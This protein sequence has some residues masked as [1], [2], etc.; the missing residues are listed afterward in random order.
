MVL[1]AL[2]LINACIFEN[3]KKPNPQGSSPE[4]LQLSG[5]LVNSEALALAGVPVSIRS[6]RSDST[7]ISLLSKVSEAEIYSDTTYSIDNGNFVFSSVPGGNFS[8]M[9]FYIPPD[10]SETLGVLVPFVK[11][12][13]DTNIGNISMLPVGHVTIEVSLNGTPTANLLC[14]IE[15]F[16]LTQ[17]TDVNGLCHFLLPKGNYVATVGDPSQGAL[18]SFSINV[19]SGEHKWLGPIMLATDTSLIPPKPQNLFASIDNYNGIVKLSWQPDSTASSSYQVF[20]KINPEG[21]Y[22][23]IH[24]GISIPQTKLEDTLALD[25]NDTAFFFY[26]VRGFRDGFISDFSDSVF[27]KATPPNKPSKPNPEKGQIV[28]NLSPFLSWQGIRIRGEEKVIY[29]VYVDT[30][31]YPDVPVVQGQSVPLVSLSNLKENTVYFWRVVA[32]VDG[33][34]V[35]GPVWYFSTPPSPAGNNI[36]SIPENAVPSDSSMDIEISDVI[37]SWSSSDEDGEDALK[38]DLYFSTNPDALNKIATGLKKNSFNLGALIASTSY[39]WQVTASDG[40]ATAIGP[41]W[42]FTTKSPTANNNPPL[43]P[44][45]PSPVDSAS[46]LDLNLTLSWKSADPDTSDELLFD[47]LFGTQTPPTQRIATGLSASRYS[48]SNLSNGTAYYWQIIATDGELTTPGKI[49]TFNTKDSVFDNSAPIIPNSPSPSDSSINQELNLLLTWVGGD[50]DIEDTINYN[51]YL[52]VNSPPTLLIGKDLQNSNFQVTGL[53]SN[54]KYYWYV[55][56]SDGKSTSKSPT[57]SFQTKLPSPNNNP[58][59]VP[60]IVSPANDSTGLDTALTLFWE[61]SDPDVDDQLVYTL[62]FGATNPPVDVITSN[63]QESRFSLSN[64]KFGTRYYWRIIS[65][66]GNES[67]EGPIWAFETVADSTPN[68]APNV[69]SS[70]T[71]ANGSVDMETNINLSWLGGD[72]D[73]ADVVQYRVYLGLDNPPTTL[74]GTVGGVSQFFAPN[75]NN[76]TNYYWRIVAEDLE[77]STQGP[78]WTFS[79][80]DVEGTG[81]ILSETW[82]NVPGLSLWDLYKNSNYPILASS[83]SMLTSFTIG[84]QLGDYYG[85]RLRGYIHPPTTGDYSFWISG[86]DY[87]ELYLSSDEDPANKVLIAYSSGYTDPLQWDKYPSQQSDLQYLQAGRKYYIE[88]LVKENEQGDH[89][90]VGWQGPGI[91]A[92]AERP[93]PGN[94]LSPY[95]GNGAPAPVITVQPVSVSILEGESAVFSV[96]AQSN[97]PVFYEWRKNGIP[98][99]NSNTASYT[100]PITSDSDDG[101]TFRVMVFNS[102]GNELSEPANLNITQTIFPP[103]ITSHPA[104]ATRTEGQSVTFSVAA[105]GTAPFSY[106]WYRNG[107]PIQNAHNASYTFITSLAD[108]GASYNVEVSNVKGS[109]FSNQAI[110]TVNRLIVAPTVT[111]HPANASVIEGNSANF[112][113]Q[114]SGT[115]PFNFQWRRNAVNITGATAANYNPTNIPLTWSGSVIDVVVSNSAG[116]DTSNTATLTVSPRPDP[117]VIT[118]EP[119]NASVIEGESAVFSITVSGTAPFNYVWLKNNN[120]IQGANQ[121]SYTTPNTNLIDN[122]SNYRVRVSNSSGAD[123]SIA[124]ILTVTERIYPVFINTQPSD[125]SVYPGQTARF[126]VAAGGTQPITFQWYRNDVAIDNATSSS[127]TTGVLSLA[128]DGAEYY[129]VATNST[130]S[131]E[132][133]HAVLTVAD[134]PINITTQPQNQSVVVGNIANFSVTASGT[135][136]SYQWRKNGSNIVGATASS[137]STPN[138]VAADDGSV[139]DVLISNG[140]GSLTS[141]E[142]TLSIIF[143]PVIISH[144]VSREA[145]QGESVSFTVQLE[146]ATGASYQWRL[147]NNNIAGAT[148]ASYVI[149]AVGSQHAG[150]YSVV[151]TNAA[152][153]SISNTA[154]L[155]VLI[156][157]GITTQPLGQN[158]VLGQAAQ[159]SVV[160]SGSPTLTYQWRRNGSPIANATS[161]SYSI[162]SVAQADSGNYSV[163][164]TNA[165]G[166]ITS[167]TARLNVIIAPQI[168]TDPQNTTAVQGETASFSVVASGSSPSYQWRQNGVNLSGQTSATLSLNNV[169]QTMN[170]NSYD[171][172]ASNA[173]GADTSASAILTVTTLTVAPVI[174]QNPVNQT[175][176]QGEPVSFSVTSTGTAPL[177][178][179]WALAGVTVGTTTTGSY[180]IA[181]A[182]PANAGSYTVTV[183]NSAGSDVSNPFSLT[184]ITPPTISAQPQPLSVAF[185]SSA[186]FSVTASGNGTLSYQW[187]KDGV[188]IDGAVSANYSIASVNNASAGEYDVVVSNSAGQVISSPALLSVSPVI[189]TQ[190]SGGSAVLGASFSFTVSAQGPGLS[191]QWVK[192]TDSVGSN[193]PTYTINPVVNSSGGSYRV[194][195]SNSAGSVT[196]NQANLTVIVPPSITSQP[197]SHGVLNGDSAMFAVVASGSNLQY[198]WR[199]EGVNIT[200]ATSSILTLNSSN[201]ASE[202]D[203]DVIVSNTAGRDTSEPAQLTVNIPA[204]ITGHPGNSSVLEGASASFSATASGSGTLSYRWHRNGVALNNGGSYTGVLSASLSINPV[205]TTHAGNFTLVVSNAYGSDTSDAATLT[206]TPAPTP[207]SIATQPVSQTVLNGNPFQFLVVASGSNLSYQWYFEGTAINNANASS[208][209]SV[210]T[211]ALDGDY[212]VVVSNSAGSVTS[213]TVSLTVNPPPVITNSPADQTVSAGSEV[214]FSVSATGTGTLSYYWK[215]DGNNFT[216]SS[217]SPDLTLTNVSNANEGS[218]TVVVTDSYGSVESS[219][220]YLT[221]NT[222]PLITTQPVSQN[223]SRGS[224]ATLSVVASGDPALTYQWYKDGTPITSG[225]G[226]YSGWNSSSLRINNLNPSLEGVYFVEVSNSFGTVTSSAVSVTMVA[227]LISQNP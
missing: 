213:N 108:N 83:S 166:S 178:Y 184:V 196:S 133:N 47:I 148:S 113:V 112:A 20:R 60:I 66:D 26:K 187:R 35:H 123:T 99:A 72:P 75:L 39:Y 139:F 17:Y 53:T 203:Y 165:A 223:L 1:S 115:S 136:L 88:A 174:T 152:G 4:F 95:V 199:F 200:G 219:P 160:A 114:L 132:S 212:Y 149:P 51:V 116:V 146:D 52:D 3:K 176:I 74:A 42:M 8:V 131:V 71:P 134:E 11:V 147:G 216:L 97:S 96:S 169:T 48:L 211:P 86:D 64:L 93:I 185:G 110:L 217:A 62:Q 43:E 15:N 124:A 29:D 107:M 181:S 14:Q 92:D 192:G 121:A 34:Q 49:W 206:V 5:T 204:T 125:T 65:S 182:Q 164:V 59:N 226:S 205:S 119:A 94:R 170:G 61:G 189:S 201:S 87:S 159:F 109:V 56:S 140:S 214:N 142:A 150:N 44:S 172:I 98:I 79:T 221:V 194:I 13:A 102:D 218:Y 22:T 67:V 91:I 208:Y 25:F 198:Q 129:V 224:T 173:A 33:F 31:D 19:F 68:S 81:Q 50:P 156:P 145:I 227:D 36:P 84:G 76:S 45:D 30:L 222:P 138:A 210:A 167:N 24:K 118:G 16:D 127:Y 161:A 190:P 120:I 89:M 27:V 55:L 23:S 73:T 197:V 100:T 143:P 163:T 37:L 215:K 183:S 7:S 101:A 207:P 175:V 180:T 126:S 195:V 85:M 32:F 117:P 41:H 202:G 154:S 130:G 220:A 153:S 186:N 188:N 6:F 191:Y 128:D 162:P 58:P 18:N 38:Y 225:M 63:I 12:A 151:V 54:T 103:T 106:S 57:W 2:L 144:P 209:G 141:Q 21:I 46:N 82:N 193:S 171:V 137:Y 157:P 104:N 177:T 77:T 80:K 105:T 28:D 155:T 70:P 135:N 9:S 90:A 179:T 78:V 122:G 69:P 158:I 168:T 111:G 10:S 40:K